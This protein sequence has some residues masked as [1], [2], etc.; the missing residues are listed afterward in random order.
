VEEH[1]EELESFFH[2]RIFGLKLLKIMFLFFIHVVSDITLT[3]T[4]AARWRKMPL[5]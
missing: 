5:L 1:E 4:Q 2:L 3:L